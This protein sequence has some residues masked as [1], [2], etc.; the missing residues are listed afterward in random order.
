MID[1]ESFQPDLKALRRILYALATAALVTFGIAL[2][3]ILHPPPQPRFTR[4]APRCTCRG[5]GACCP[6]PSPLVKA[7]K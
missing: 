2:F 4:V 7:R 6:H 3:L 1:Y 5:E